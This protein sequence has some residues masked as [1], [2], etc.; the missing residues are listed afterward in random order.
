MGSFYCSSKHQTI[1]LKPFA[2][3][4]AAETEIVRYLF[5]FLFVTPPFLN[6]TSDFRFNFWINRLTYLTCHGIKIAGNK[7]FC[8]N[9]PFVISIAHPAIR[10]ITVPLEKTTLYINFEN[11]LDVR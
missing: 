8:H 2:R 9:A 4:V 6:T 10:F 1:K 7:S 3:M 11:F 5:S